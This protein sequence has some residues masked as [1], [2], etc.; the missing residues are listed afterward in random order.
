MHDHRAAPHERL[1]PGSI[2]DAVY[3]DEVRRTEEEPSTMFENGS[4]PAFEVGKGECSLRV[5]PDCD[6]E[7]PHA[8]EPLLT[9]GRL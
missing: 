5:D 4:D 7:P 6:S 3:L 8:E 1:P 2:G 9:R